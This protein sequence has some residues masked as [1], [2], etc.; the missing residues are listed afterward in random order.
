M[1]RRNTIL[2]A[3]FFVAPYALGADDP[4]TG[5]LQGAVRFESDALTLKPLVGKSDPVRENEVCSFD[6]V[7]D[8]RL[9]VNQKTQGVQNVLV[10]IRKLDPNTPVIPL[11]P[12]LKPIRWAIK[13]C[14]LQPHVLI[15]PVQQ[16]LRFASYDP[17]RHRPLEYPVAGQP[18]DVSLS[19]AYSLPTKQDVVFAEPNPLPVPVKCSYHPWI[20]GYRLTLAHPFAT[21]SKADGTFQIKNV[22]YGQ[23]QIVVWHELRGYLLK[24]TINVDKPKTL[25]PEIAYQLTPEEREELT[26]R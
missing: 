11:K 5:I 21:V 4:A 8:E 26:A 16:T 14:R 10:W 19:P 9:L 13:D 18:F 7:P 23:H 22:P 3:L 20:T 12:S 6:V 1:L 24:A 15:I 17:T 25:I 2:T